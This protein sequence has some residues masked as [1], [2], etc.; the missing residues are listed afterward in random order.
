MYQLACAL[1]IDLKSQSWTGKLDNWVETFNYQVEVAIAIATTGLGKQQHVISQAS[2]LL[3]T[4][5]TV[6]LL[7]SWNVKSKLDN[8][9][10]MFNY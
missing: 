10:E 4:N 1:T 5:W 7:V 6:P 8:L 9:V 3:C 2:I